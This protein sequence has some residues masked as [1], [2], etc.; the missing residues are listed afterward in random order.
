MQ[1][2]QHKVVTIDYVLKDDDGKVLDASEG[3]DGFAYLHGASNIIPGLER[4]LEGKEAGDEVNVTVAPDDG[5][6]ERDNALVQSV[7][8]DRFQEA[9]GVEVGMFFHTQ[10]QDGSVHVVTVVGIDEESVT[11]DANHPLAGNNLNFEVKVREVRDATDEE[12]S[13]GHVHGADAHAHE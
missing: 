6:G 8:R 12:K 3:D 10:A 9:D 4:A 2:A 7:P 5:Y 13:H 11:V 1:I